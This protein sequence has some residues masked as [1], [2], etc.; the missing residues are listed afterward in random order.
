M[1]RAH[2]IC[3][4]RGSQRKSAPAWR[5]GRPF[6]APPAECE[7]RFSSASMWQCPQCSETVDD[8]FEVCWNCSV[9]RELPAHE[10]VVPDAPG[11]QQE[12]RIAVLAAIRAALR[13]VV[14][15]PTTLPPALAPLLLS[16]LEH[17]FG[18]HDV[19]DTGTRM[20]T[21]L[22]PLLDVELWTS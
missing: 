17:A 21:V 8:D 20:S 3:K 6:D 22:T 11:A 2:A 5:D 15:H 14:A 10:D 7:T 12:R 4:Y 13:I 19:P 9:P 16:L 1:R 18:P